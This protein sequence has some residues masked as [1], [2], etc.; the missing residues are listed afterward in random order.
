M[1]GIPSPWQ[2]DTTSGV[3]RLDRV[4]PV[5]FLPAAVE[6]VA[7]FAH[8]TD[9][10]AEIRWERSGAELGHVT[11]GMHPSGIPVDESHRIHV[12]PDGIVV[13][14]ATEEGAF[15]AMTTIGHAAATGTMECGTVGD[16]PRFGWRGLC[17]DVARTPLP[18]DDVRQI[19][20]VLA[21]LKLNVLHLHL[22]DD[23]GWRLPVEGRPELALVGG[24]MAMAG[25]PGFAYGSEEYAEFE[26]WARERH[27][28]VVP[29]IDMPGHVGALLKTYP[30]LAAGTGTPGEY[31]SQLHLDPDS[32]EVYELIADVLAAAARLHGSPYLHIGGDEAFGMADEDY[33]RVLQRAIA[34]S[35]LDPER[36]I[37][38]QEGVRADAGIGTLQ[39][40]RDLDRA[41]LESDPEVRRRLGLLAAADLDSLTERG[42]QDVA[43][44]SAE[45]RNVVLSPALVSYL[46]RPYAEAAVLAAGLS[47][48]G[49]PIYSPH[50]V[51]EAFEFSV[52]DVV[53]GLDS[54]CI[55]GIEAA[56]WTET[57][58]DLQTAKRM[59]L[60]RLAGIA[61]RAWEQE[62][63][64]WGAHADRLRTLSANWDARGFDY[65]RSE[66]VWRDDSDPS[67]SK[68]AAE[69]S[70]A[71][72]C[73]PVEEVYDRN[74]VE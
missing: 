73:L 18:L 56:L 45:G 49:L 7:R 43:R 69:P 42:R 5:G 50:T 15:R 6:Q 39:V 40:W 53:P 16:A 36:V 34:G 59:L 63:E 48:V 67:A 72:G 51:Q 31:A 29:E 10:G 71:E 38:W 1:S 66:V 17:L 70:L 68:L 27:V 26:A 3:L 9:D 20:D 13:V 55:V 11:P 24:A 62:P 4:C 57:I 35:G 21:S 64:P 47:G 8:V 58:A 14:A 25:R 32:D 60:P 74:L 23:Q 22:T 54:A 61:Q 52:D 37:A 41:G 46:D 28:W 44:I 65:F 19:V 33:R 30:H 2:V 12:T